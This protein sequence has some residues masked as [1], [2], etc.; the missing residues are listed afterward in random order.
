V[1]NNLFLAWGRFVYRARVKVIVLAVA[2]IGVA[3]IYG[4]DLAHQ[5]SQGGWFDDTSESVEGSKLADETFGRDRNGDVIALYTPLDGKRVD[6]PELAARAKAHLANLLEVEKDRIVKID[7]YWDGALPPDKSGTH[8]FA[9]IGL[10]G[11]DAVTLDEYNAIKGELEID[12][13]RLQLAGVQPV[14]D[15]LNEGMQRDIKRAEVIALPLVAVLLYFVFGGVIAA[16]LPVIIG[17]MTILASQG[18]MRIITNFIDVNAFAS[19]VV[20]LVSLGLA[21]DY[22]LFIVTRFREELAE[23][24]SVEDAVAR[25][26][27]TAGRTIVFSASII[28]VCLAGLLIYP[29]GVLR[30]VP[31]GAISSVII[32]AGLSISVLPAVL[33]IL[34]KRIDLL[35]WDRFSQNKSI[36]QIDAGFWSKLAKWAMRR[37]KLL[38][39]PIVAG[40][41]AMII[42]FT[43]MEFAGL[44]ERYLSPTDSARVAQ[45][46][47]DE[48]FPNYR[49]EPI[50]LVIVGADPAQLNAIY[51]E[52]NQVPGLT[53]RFD[54]DEPESKGINVLKA[55]LLDKTKAD[56]VVDELRAIDI[57]PNVTMYVAGI[58]ALEYDSIHGLIKRLPL[59]VVILLIASFLLM[60]AAF[61]SVVLAVKAIVISAL[62]LGATLGLLTWVFVDGHGAEL[63][64]F[65]PGPIM[66]AVLIVI[67]TVIFGLSTDYEV[68]LMSRMVEARESGADT[69][70]A[71]RYG[72]AHTGGVI[73]AAASI[74]IVVTGAFAMSDLVLMKCLAYGMIA[75]LVLDATLIRMLLVPAVMKVLGD[76]CWWAPRW[77]TVLHKKIALPTD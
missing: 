56:V 66:F 21:I 60:F 37:P 3:G 52:A 14:V 71:I 42:P 20:T 43:G 41:I 8:A 54:P 70:E 27:A 77:L 44:S 59:L 48:L 32:A 16:S 63:L 65:T 28:V 13:M 1:N 45:Q 12:G 29:H 47:F 35:V 76:W 67:V 18:L 4:L 55:G 75:A 17:G 2:F 39:V 33:G 6:D 73:T 40:L 51:D 62:S 72:I 74:L 53:G 61:G 64:G 26:V 24:R 34:G 22:G 7:S 49:T 31:Y 30:S 15:A 23:G 50:R 25:S 19:A 5:L 46:D 69:P 57:P 58:P 10:R 9:S 11:E 36:E 68:F 38:I